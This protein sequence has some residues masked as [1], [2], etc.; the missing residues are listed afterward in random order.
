MSI[1][2]LIT[3]F[4]VHP[5]SIPFLTKITLFFIFLVPPPPPTHSTNATGP[6]P[7]TRI[8]I[9]IYIHMSAMA[10]ALLLHPS[11]PW[12][13]P[14]AHVLAR[15]SLR[16]PKGQLDAFSPLAFIYSSLICPVR[17][18]QGRHTPPPPWSHQ[19]TQRAATLV[20][21]TPPS[22]LQLGTMPDY[23]HHHA[24]HPMLGLQFRNTCM[25]KSKSNPRHTIPAAAMWDGVGRWVKGG[26]EGQLPLRL[27][28]I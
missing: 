21:P 14:P 17:K 4:A 12:M 19:S 13:S 5:P 26:R 6:P 8:H 2:V 10:M 7:R 23:H 16:S 15:P 25:Q 18:K 1:H 28:M 22:S 9:Y 11:S 24:T 3:T 27:W 20:S